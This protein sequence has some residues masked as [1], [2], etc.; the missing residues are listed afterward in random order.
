MVSKLSKLMAVAAL[1]AIPAISSAAQVA[2]STAGAFTTDSG[3]SGTAPGQ[4]LAVGSSITFFGAAAGDSVT[5]AFTGVDNNLTPVDAPITA[6]LGM[7]TVTSTGA[8]LTGTSFL[9]DLH[10]NF[11]LTINQTNPSASPT[12][13]TGNVY[14][15]LGGNI[16]VG[17]T[18][19]GGISVQF[20]PATLDI[21]G[22]SYELQITSGRLA[23]ATD[24]N[25]TTLKANIFYDV[26]TTST[27]VPLPASV[28]G[29]LG[30]MAV[31]GGLQIRRK[32]AK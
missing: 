26:P 8:G 3:F 29:G 6:S 21:A 28:W 1:V 11:A 32:L 14:S 13:T 10:G 31:L 22:V 18:S 12:G 9:Q 19:T 5:V 7:F 24:G 20:V 25:A 30:T 17:T 4:S 2:Y 23:L 15:T 16:S 27:A